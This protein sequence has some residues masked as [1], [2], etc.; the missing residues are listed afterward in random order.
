M[1]MWSKTEVNHIRVSLGRCDAQQLSNEL[2]R[3]REKVKLKIRE[4][5]IKEKLSS[6]SENAKSII[7]SRD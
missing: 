3:S 1:V 6:L 7:P 5:K 4:I 2:G